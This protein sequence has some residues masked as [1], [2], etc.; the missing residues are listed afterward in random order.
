MV[1]AFLSLQGHQLLQV[2]QLQY[3]QAL[4]PRLLQVVPFLY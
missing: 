4:A 1:V 3:L 2:G